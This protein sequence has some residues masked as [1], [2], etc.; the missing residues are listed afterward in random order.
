MLEPSP[1]GAP[2]PTSF[3]QRRRPPGLAAVLALLVLLGSWVW[4]M[5]ALAQP[6]EANGQSAAA[7][8]PDAVGPDARPGI[9]VFYDSSNVDPT[10][11]PI[12]GG[13]FK[14]EW[15]KIE[16]GPEQYD[17]SD[18]DAWLGRMSASNKPAAI[19]VATYN[20]TCCGGDLTPV[21]IVQQYPDLKV[22]CDDNWVIPKYWD[23]RYL[24]A[25]GRFIRAFGQ[26]FDGDPRLEFVEIGVGLY[27]ETK[28]SDSMHVECLEKAG[29]T[30]QAWVQTARR[31]M[32]DYRAAFP[33]T[34][35][36]LMY[37]PFFKDVTERRQMTDYAA[38]LGIGLKHNGLRPDSDATNINN[39]N[40][41]LYGSGQYDPMFKWWQDVSIG[42]ESYEEQYMTGLTNT[43]WGVLSGLDKHADYFVFSK[44]LVEKTDR[45]PILAF[46]QQ[47]LGKTIATSPS[48]WVAMR[49]TE[50]DWY[51]QR[52]NYDF[53]MV[54]NDA[55]P[56]GR[57]VALFNISTSAEGRY[58]RRTDSA[59]GNPFMYFD[60]EDDFLHDATGR[61]RIN[62]TYYDKG[63]DKFDVYYDAWSSANKLAGT[64]TKTNSSRWLKASWT[65]T[66]ARFANRQPGGGDHP[67]SDL[68]LFARNDGDET[69]HMVQVE[70]LDM[71]A[72]P[73]PSPTPAIV[74]TPTPAW[75]PEPP[76]YRL[77]RTYRQG[78]NGYTGASDAYIS[79]WNPTANY[80][81][82]N[83]LA[84]RSEHAMRGLIRFDGLSLPAGAT[85]D[86]AT[87]KVF[88]TGSSNSGSLYLRAFDLLR[89]F[90]ATQTTYTLA[91]AGS[92]WSEPGLGA[93][94]YASPYNDFKFVN[95]PNRW[96]TLDVTAA[97]RRWLQNPGSNLGLLL[98]GYS[99]VRV[100]FDLASSEYE[101][102]SFRPQLVL[103]YIN[104]GFVPNT[105]TP[106]PTFDPNA[107][108]TPTPTATPAPKLIRAGRGSP[109]IDGDLSEWSLQNPVRL[110]LTTA[111]HFSG[112]IPQPDDLSGNLW[113]VWDEAGFYVAARVRDAQAVVDSAGLWH[114]DSV[115]IAIDGEF[116][117]L[118]DSASGGDHQF[119]GRRDGV[120]N[121]RALPTDR[122][123]VAVHERSD[124]YDLEMAVPAAT[125]GGRQP[126]PGLQLGFNWGL[127]DDDDGGDRDSAMI[128]SGRSTYAGA[129]NFGVLL[130]QESLATNTPGPSPTPTP[131][132]S[133]TPTPTRGPTATP[134]A[135]PT[136]TPT[137]TRTPTPTNTPT[138]VTIQLTAN[139][140][141]YYSQ[142][143]P[144][145]NYGAADLLSVRSENV[146]EAFLAFPLEQ[147]PANAQVLEAN[148]HL[149]VQGRSN[150]LPLRLDVQRLNRS[151]TELGLTW[152]Q[153]SENTAWAQAGAGAVPADRAATIYASANL[154]AT[155]PVTIPVTSLVADWVQGGAGNYGLILHGVSSG[156]VQ[157][158]I[159]SRE[160]TDPAARP[161]LAITYRGGGSPATPTPSATPTTASTTVTPTP[162]A[163]RTP[164][165]PTATPTRTPTVTPRPSAT[166]SPTATPSATHTASPTVT[167][168]L[169]GGVQSGE[170]ILPA[171][172]DADINLWYP[173][174]NTGAR[175]VMRVRGGGIMQS[176]LNFDLA[177]ALPVRAV[178]D[179]A[180]L[181]LWVVER[182][183]I[184][185][186]SATAYMLRRP[187]DETQ[188]THQR[189]T[190]AAAWQTAGAFGSDDR[191]PA[192]LATVALPEAGLVSWDVTQAA[193]RWATDPS[194][195]FG[196]ILTGDEGSYVHYGLASREHFDAGKQPRLVVL[197]HIPPTPTPSP[198]TTRTP[199]ATPTRT[200]TRTPTATPTRTPTPTDTPANPGARLLD[201]AF[202]SATID[203]DLG[204]WAGP[205]LQLD[206]TTAIR[207]SNPGAILGPADSSALVRARWDES[208]LYLAID[209]RDD[210][211]FND[212]VDLWR[213]DS[214]EI[215]VDGEDDDLPG[216]PTG[217]DH[218][219]TIR[220]DG[221]AADRSLPVSGNVRWAARATPGGY[222]IEIGIP[223]SQLGG[224]ALAALRT[225]GIDFSL[226]DDDEGGDRDSYLIW[227]SASTYNDAAHFGRLTLLAPPTPTPTPTPT[228]TAS[229]TPTPTW[230]PRPTATPTAT[231]TA[232]LPAAGEATLLPSADAYL[233]AWYPDANYGASGVLLLRPQV[234]VVLLQFDLGPLPP[235]S[236]ILDATLALATL[237]RTN[238]QALRANLYT[239]RRPWAERVA[240]YYLADVGQNWAA[241]LAG[242][243]GDRDFTPFAAADLPTSG[244]TTLDVTAL[245]RQWR[246]EPGQNFGLL[247]EGAS[248]GAV[249]QSL[250]AREW[251][252]SSQR[253]RLVVHYAPATPTPTLTPTPAETPT[254]TPTFTL[255]PTFTPTFTPTPTFTAT[256]TF[257][258]IPTATPTPT[259]TATP[260]PA[261][262]RVLGNG[263]DTYIDSAFPNM[264]FGSA[265]IL[266]A[267]NP[268]AAHILLNFDLAALPPAAIVQQATLRLRL[269]DGPLPA[270]VTFDL[271]PLLRYW[272]PEVATW[273]KAD[274]GA[275]WSQPGASGPDDRWP[276]PLTSSDPLTTG[277]YVS[278]DV[279]SLVQDWMIDP[280]TQ[281]GMLIAARSDQAQSL[282]LASFHFSLADW[283][284]RLELVLAQ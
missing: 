77:T 224:Q 222:R 277:G 247:I 125:W 31:I 72:T 225:I 271:Y 106:T 218:Q 257:T 3:S 172:A 27:G 170:I 256:P 67:G 143:A 65:L 208:Y 175:S 45:H 2:A 9:Y 117:G 284:P 176:L 124:G 164:L 79:S 43:T 269:L 29:L 197:Y 190:L 173:A 223:P 110:D 243:P 147:L 145:T 11:N 263:V 144:A 73:V 174:E 189:A 61:V 71:P 130:L 264:N 80:G 280:S 154:A 46:A 40:Y 262:W 163:T 133:R 76:T 88:T 216:S 47:H 153:A 44:A 149:A 252:Q 121:D 198:T 210:F 234:S 86:R 113:V 215:G 126:A 213:D 236:T 132:P 270:P 248:G 251:T 35:I 129:E 276:Q 135:T 253:P 235:G 191:D 206:P 282:N 146:M 157:Y 32:D 39:P 64:V 66:D 217:G 104:P 150:T 7:S 237:S 156:R 82:S 165:A 74:A 233:S 48:A 6:G 151:W 102:L 112:L 199:T 141:A 119:T 70:R 226:N 116:D 97:V 185:P 200:P 274:A 58:T 267:I 158:D 22:V 139:A 28:P 138:P 42:W 114:D 1:H 201:A 5:Q 19:G 188:V 245:A 171:A 10:A 95:T 108:A 96:I 279:T 50:W 101:T 159:G 281:R 78:E 60:I 75:T 212:S 94:D 41:S 127:N 204:E 51:P 131:T 23:A 242:G 194:A 260:T 57:T 258:P 122:V 196:L 54:Q 169:A 178:V 8:G 180:L 166:P 250:A 255:T 118:S 259:A 272:H 155:G 98:D 228:D 55:A 227:A 120:V 186:L 89:T 81:S 202:G 4:A 273:T 278:F 241:P 21:H 52:G 13:H 168:T 107:T 244:W 183:N 167:P 34:E 92:P 254:P 261:N 62:V 134:T 209:V 90:D 187:W 56:G 195:A 111:S 229:P 214:I 38:S 91:R 24:D 230:T 211:L 231:L 181:Q 100:Q 184:N 30:S 103:E 85:L 203:G 232:T 18:V 246:A 268:N 160:Q 68:S 15:N 221:A 265:V 59:T 239:L 179:S 12:T 69:I 177:P 128:W 123:T 161:I 26:R 205:S 105:P 162:T 63:T 53:F 140:D 84:I 20:A 36:M 49:E 220:F 137:A 266:Q 109:T 275:P 207:V 115:E 148:L 93:S 14:F 182:S 152:V 99:T 238:S 219:Y 25:Y 240:T 142:W 249:Q 16:L 83:L 136:R 17:W 37:S 33:R 192:R 87:L 283:R 193:Q